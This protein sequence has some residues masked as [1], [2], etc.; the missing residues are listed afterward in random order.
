V[1]E[2]IQQSENKR[3]PEVKVSARSIYTRQ[4]AV[5]SVKFEADSQMT[6]FGGLVIF[7]ALFQRLDLWNGLKECCSHLAPNGY[8]SHAVALRLL[9]VHLL[10][11]FKRLRDT[12]FYRSDPM[13]LRTL[14]LRRIPSVST[15]S[16]LLGDFDEKSVGCLRVYVRDGVLGRLV[17]H[18]FPSLTLDFDGS[19]QSTKRHAEGTA[20]GFNKHHKGWR[21][22]YP[23]FC[24]VAQ[25]G[26]VLNVLHRS[27]NVHDSNGALAFIEQCIADVRAVLPKVRI[28]VRL[29][30]A[31]FSDA[32]VRK[33]EELGVTYT[34]SVPFERFAELKRMIEAQ[35]SW[36]RVPGRKNGFFFEERWKP[37]SWQAKTRFVFIRTR[38][39]KQDKEPLQLDLFRP[40]DSE[41]Q[42]KV[43]VT[44]K[45]TGAGRVAAF[46]EGRGY[47]EKILG[48]M[49]QDVQMEYIPC[50][51]R[52]ANEVWLL[53]SMLTHNLGRELQLQA[54]P[55]KRPAS[56]KRTALWVFESIEMLRRKIVQR[57]AR[58][59][60][61]QGKWT[62]TLPEIPA[63][64][65]AIERYAA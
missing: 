31:F 11:G 44:N 12:E 27:G 36:Q 33:L 50:R 9:V 52:T 38:E 18:Q 64:R 57:A 48:D 40:S 3:P 24:T 28:E 58:L 54:L 41:W 6:S 10:L 5:P 62:L 56:M 17:I 1:F 15:V 13:V 53:T 65:S 22:Y 20:V 51:K 59:T 43:V 37:E 39:R 47:Q 32:T 26:Q 46:H 23:L 60:R 30:S 8:Y 25:T 63:L 7:Q 4:R 29:D 16:R 42:F 21:S 19:V 55:Q 45:S 14:E 2:D 35:R 34:I 61:P 49:K